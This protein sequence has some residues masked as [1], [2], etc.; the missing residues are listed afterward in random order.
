MRN[1]IISIAIVIMCLGCKE[2]V[3]N[4]PECFAFNDV[5]NAT[6]GDT[7]HSNAITI[8]GINTPISIDIANGLYSVNGGEYT[9]ASGT[10]KNGDHVRVSLTASSE[11]ETLTTA[12]LYVGNYGSDFKVTT[13]FGKHLGFMEQPSV[14]L[15]TICTSNSIKIS[16]ME[17]PI[18]V[19]IT[20][21]GT[22]SVNGGIFTNTAGAIRNG[23]TVAVRVKS[24]ASCNS[25]VVTTITIGKI[26]DTFAVTT[27]PQLTACDYMNTLGMTFKLIP[28][29]TF[30]MGDP[31]EIRIAVP[32]TV[33]I[34]KP[35]YMQT[36]LLTRKQWALIARE[37]LSDIDPK[38]NYPM[39]GISWDD[40]QECVKALNTLKQGTYRLPTEAE[41]EYCCKAGMEN[42]PELDTV[43]W[44]N[45]NSEGSIHPVAQ[46]LPNAWGLYD[47]HGNAFE[48]CS[49]VYEPYSTAAVT[50]PTGAIQTNNGARFNYTEV[51][52]D[53]VTKRSYDLNGNVDK[54]APKEVYVRKSEGS[55]IRGTTT[56]MIIR[57]GS[58]FTSAQSCKSTER[59]V[60][61]PKRVEDYIGLR[62]VRMK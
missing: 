29:G 55:T 44:Y 47:M 52:Y 11:Y 22:Y 7:V 40:A 17:E 25:K 27:V 33:T 43:G 56:D 20:T 21:G 19:S 48:M 53:V 28:A 4:I 37:N 12:T 14:A 61:T 41:W 38:D 39:T 9:D 15:D 62:V 58:W 10:V 36:T 23:D 26:T 32:H 45:G 35:F 13:C 59:T 30:T 8:S 34:S 46:K 1:L 50:D 60:T 3:K 42:D 51:N 16:G 57:G 2:P 5:K 54:T 18:N 31:S 6:L 24:S 49:D